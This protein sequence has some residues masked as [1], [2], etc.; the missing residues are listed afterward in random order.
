MQA[1][2]IKPQ[3]MKEK[4]AGSSAAFRERARR[5]Q[6]PKPCCNLLARRPFG[7]PD[8]LGRGLSEFDE[9]EDRPSKSQSKPDEA[10]ETF[11]R[12]WNVY[13]SVTPKSDAATLEDLGPQASENG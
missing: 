9:S 4:T 7:S 10:L 1:H 13:A 3:A 12:R 8:E 11:A 2:A 6:T 5:S